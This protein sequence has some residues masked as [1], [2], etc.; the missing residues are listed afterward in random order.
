MQ[1]RFFNHTLFANTKPYLFLFSCPLKC[2]EK[3]NEENR[4][5]VFK[6]F[7]EIGTKNEQD[8]YLQGQIQVCGVQRRTTNNAPGNEK[9]TRSYTH[10][11]K[12][13]G[14]NIKVCQKAFLSIHSI[15]K[16]R[17][18]RIKV[19]L[20]NNQTPEDKR[21][22]NVKS[23]V[24]GQQHREEIREH[25]SCF[26][27]KTSHYSNREYK[28]L[29]AELNVKIMYSLFKERYPNSP[30]KYSY[31]IKFFK[32]NFDLHFGRPQVD[33]CNTCEDLSLKIKN[34]KLND[35]AKRV[36][37][38][39]KIVHQRRA[40]KFYNALKATTDECKQREDLT[41]FCFD[42]MQNL[43]LPEFPTQDK[44]YL[45]Q[46]TVSLF[47]ITDLKTQK[48]FFYIYHEG[49]AAKGPNEVCSFILDYIKNVAPEEATELRLFCDN[50]PG[51]NKNHTVV[52][53]CMALK[54][55]GRFQKI[56]QY[57]PIRGHSFLPCDRAF[58]TIKRKLRRFDR[59][60]NLHQYT[61]LIVLSSAKNAFTVKEIK[62]K[63]IMNFK[64]WWPK[65]YKLNCIS[66]ETKTEKDRNKKVQFSVS[67]FHHL[68]YDEDNVVKASEFVNGMMWHTFKDLRQPQTSKS[69]LKLPT[70]VAYKGPLA[71]AAVKLDNLK[72]LLRWV[73][74]ENKEYYHNILRNHPPKDEKAKKKQKVEF[75]ICFVN[76]VI[77]KI[78]IF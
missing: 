64:S 18:Q 38:A 53:M 34:P 5:N 76:L 3:V 55:T 60:Y 9:R 24:V 20:S 54:A 31:Y 6:I 68:I 70:T 59:V 21:G 67:K 14:K 26:P 11:V 36:A 57:Y 78:K 42:F 49:Q 27:V 43:Q 7:Y 1:V 39:E 51:Q 37:V 46:L 50:C 72:T 62:T 16:Q 75:K 40:N 13:G 77:D 29:D 56:T 33:V 69:V 28:Y 44:F 25:I 19:L 4:N 66:N 15:S 17:L 23:N 45:S 47:C 48:S 30:V 52:R 71:I 32:E 74:E 73:N 10:F 2:F 58:G 65:F 61:E 8:I 63:D 41:A 22:K 12:I 35:G